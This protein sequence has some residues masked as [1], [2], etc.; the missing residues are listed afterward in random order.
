M[1]GIII[2]VSDNT[3]STATSTTE[4]EASATTNKTSGKSTL[5]KSGKSTAPKGGKGTAPKGGKS[6]APKGGKNSAGKPVKEKTPKATTPKPS[7]PNPKKDFSDGALVN[8]I[9]EGFSTSSIIEIYR[10][11]SDEEKAE[12]KALGI[13]HKLG[14]SP[15]ANAYPIMNEDQLR[16]LTQDIANNG[17]HVP[18]RIAKIKNPAA[19]K[20]TYYVIDGRNRIKACRQCG[21]DP[22]YVVRDLD[23]VEDLNKV[24]FNE[25]LSF[26]VIRRHMSPAQ[27]AWV[28]A[29]YVDQYGPTLKREFM[30][31]MQAA[32]KQK[33]MLLD[34]KAKELI[35]ADSNFQTRDFVAGA[36]SGFSVKDLRAGMKP[37]VSGRAIDQ[38]REI[39]V[40]CKGGPAYKEVWARLGN[41]ELSLS[42]AKREIALL[43]NPP[44]PKEEGAPGEN[45]ETGVI[46]EVDLKALAAKAKEDGKVKVSKSELAFMVAQLDHYITTYG[47]E[48]PAAYAAKLQTGEAKEKEEE[49]EDAPS[50][51]KED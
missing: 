16:G 12:I 13:A 10:E 21:I 36:L 14:V 22:V 45:V 33:G 31:R 3:E 39:L 35:E 44:T 6:T 20:G 1:V 25:T 34:E 29:N 42:A 5:P 41:G 7:K 46:G 28:G 26:N 24:A 37:V 51:D 43:D 8:Q 18:V 47:Y 38:A 32:Y 19:N 30:S 40:A 23:T 2:Y 15:A 27:Y 4:A 49:S 11:P 17:Q 50:F 9:R 48:V